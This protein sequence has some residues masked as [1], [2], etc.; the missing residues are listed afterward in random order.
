MLFRRLL[1]QTSAFLEQ[2]TKTHLPSVREKATVWSWKHAFHY[3]KWRPVQTSARV[4]D[5]SPFFFFFSENSRC[6]INSL[7]YLEFLAI[8]YFI[9]LFLYYFGKFDMNFFTQYLIFFF[10]FFCLICS[11][12]DALFF[13]IFFSKI[14]RNIPSEILS[15]KRS[16]QW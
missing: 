16:M 5:F 4:W 15:V 9:Y 2:R 13:E 3:G 6:Q 7:Y 11:F 8:D 1:K 10:F 12:E 14:I